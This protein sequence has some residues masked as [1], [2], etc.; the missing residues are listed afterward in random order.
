MLILLDTNHNQLLQQ[1]LQYW[2]CNSKKNTTIN[3]NKK[4]VSSINTQLE[5][6]LS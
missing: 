6:Y 5:V 1:T 2:Q 3:L 4:I